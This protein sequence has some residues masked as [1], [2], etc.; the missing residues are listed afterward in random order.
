MMPC[1]WEGNRRSGVVL[2][3]HHRLQWFIHLWA[4]GLRKGDEHPAYARYLFQSN[5]V[6][7]TFVVFMRRNSQVMWII[8]PFL[9][10]LN[11]KLSYGSYTCHR[12]WMDKVS[13]TNLLAVLEHLMI[14]MNGRH[15]WMFHWYLVHSIAQNRVSH[16]AHNTL[17]TEVISVI[18]ICPRSAHSYDS[19]ERSAT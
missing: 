4:Q 11:K 10:Q 3:M 19:Q 1:G 16:S 18:S 14:F 5:Y 17:T 15:R 7:G 8:E 13:V 2:A 12:Q 6:A 9:W